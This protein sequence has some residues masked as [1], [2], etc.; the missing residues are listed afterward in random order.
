MA[1]SDNPD[2]ITTELKQLLVSQQYSSNITL[3]IIEL[4]DDTTATVELATNAVSP[5]SSTASTTPPAS[6]LALTMN[7]HQKTLQTNSPYF[8]SLDMS[9]ETVEIN[10]R[11]GSAR[12]V[13]HW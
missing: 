12:F 10:V 7:V 3:K 9:G 4:P 13:E 2:H 1:E 8:A 6:A 11:H 5:T